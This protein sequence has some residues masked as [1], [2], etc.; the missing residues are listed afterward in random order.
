MDIRKATLSD[1]EKIQ[2]VYA[3]ARAYMR[4]TDNP[5]Q[6][7]QHAPADHILRNDIDKGQLYVIQEDDIEGVFALIPG[8]DPTYQYIEGKWLNDKPYAAIHRVA[9][10]GNK[11]GILEVCL[12][13]CHQI[14]PE[15]KI[16][17]HKDNLIMQ[18]LLCKHGFIQCGTIYLA[19]G[20]PRIAYQKSK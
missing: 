16:D 17:T 8:D 2:A 18:H 19:N 13:Y 12:S 4:Q 5:N 6:W 20:D 15:L 1:W 14:Y 3:R 11:K 9:S 7:G 10:A